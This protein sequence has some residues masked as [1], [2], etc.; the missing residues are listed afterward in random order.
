M[1]MMRTAT[2]RRREAVNRRLPKL[3]RKMAKKGAKNVR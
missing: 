3:V 1:S 2:K